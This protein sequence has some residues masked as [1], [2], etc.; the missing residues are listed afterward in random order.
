M[1]NDNAG[2]DSEFSSEEE[3]EEADKN[4]VDPLEAE[5][6]DL[7]FQRFVA[8]VIRK[9]GKVVTVLCKS[10][11]TKDILVKHIQAQLNIELKLILDLN[12]RWISFL[13]MIKTFVKVEK[14]IRI[15]LA[16]SGTS[17]TTTLGETEILKS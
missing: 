6:I 2:S 12:T 8:V 7:Y 11:F 1:E 17:V 5:T 3:M 14:R 16:K 10:P 13:E 4:I 15:A 9:V